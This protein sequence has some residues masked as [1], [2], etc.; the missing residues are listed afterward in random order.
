MNPDVWLRIEKEVDLGQA[1]DGRLTEPSR[2]Q[3]GLAAGPASEAEGEAAPTGLDLLALKEP[4]E[5]V[6]QLGGRRVAV[7][8]SLLQTFQADGLQVSWDRGARSARGFGFLA[9]HQGERLGDIGTTKRRS[10]GQKVVE[11]RPQAVDVGRCRDRPAVCLLGCHVGR[12]AE[13]GAGS[14]E[15]A[16]LV[17]PLGQTEVC[18]QRAAVGVDQDIGRLQ[19]AV[20]DA[21]PV[22]VI[23]GAS[24]VGQQTDRSAGVG[25]K[26]GK[27]GSEAAA[28]E[29]SHAEVR[30]SEAPT[31]FVDRNDLRMLKLR[32]GLSLGPESA[33][34]GLGG[35]PAG[36]DHFQGHDPVETDLSRPIHHTHATPRDFL[37]QL[38]IAEPPA[39]DDRGSRE[40]WVAVGG[41]RGGQLAKGFLDDVALVG[42]SQAIIARI[43][44]VPR[45][46]TKLDFQSQ[47]LQQKPAPRNIV[48][49]IAEEMLDPRFLALP[50]VRLEL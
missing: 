48:A 16:A 47:Q 12:R 21:S 11:D 39:L 19:V 22:S 20:D 28:G 35:E 4:I 3:I 7:D 40:N 31:D 32:Y 15:A 36:E 46:A 38:V 49:V 34:F 9:E 26:P 8:G 27:L 18:N 24:D 29:K 25:A 42:K 17:D 45:V 44:V 14:R 37:D 5:V 2:G 10:A 13:H 23:D 41:Q 6:G 30:L 33:D 1:D 50:P 43:G